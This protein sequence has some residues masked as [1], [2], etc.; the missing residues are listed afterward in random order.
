MEFQ[1]RAGAGADLAPD[2]AT[3]AAAHRDGQVAVHAA[4]EAAEFHSAGRVSRHARADVAAEG[5]DVHL[6]ELLGTRDVEHD[7]A[8]ERL[9]VDPTIDA[10]DIEP[11]REGVEV[12][13]RSERH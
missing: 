12:Q 2:V 10:G 11:S 3:A 7:V 13:L 1:R 9:R 5:L 4:A 8:A 6:L